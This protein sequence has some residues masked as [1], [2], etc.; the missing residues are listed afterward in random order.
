MSEQCCLI[1]LISFLCIGNITVPVSNCDEKYYNVQKVS[2]TQLC[3]YM[4]YW[5]DY[6][7]QS[8]SDLP[9]LYLKVY[10]FTVSVHYWHFNLNF[11]NIHSM[12]FFLKDWH[13]TQDFPEENIYRV[14]QYF[15]SDWLNEYYSAKT[16][17]QDDYRFVYMGPRGSW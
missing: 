6:S 5:Q 7:S 11:L 3:D 16:S 12:F 13:F 9:C 10:A 1:F 14:P 2:D 15:A 8:D 4:K 17:I